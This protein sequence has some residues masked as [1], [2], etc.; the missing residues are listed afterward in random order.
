M[1][2]VRCRLSAAST[3]VQLQ[4]SVTEIGSGVQLIGNTVNFTDEGTPSGTGNTTAWGVAYL[5]VVTVPSNN[6]RT[7]TSPNGMGIN[8]GSSTSYDVTIGLYAARSAGAGVLYVND[9]IFVPIDE[10]AIRLISTG[11]AITAAAT[12]AG[13]IYDNTGYMTHGKP[14]EYATLA[15]QNVTNYSEY[16]R[17]EIRG[18]PIYLTP[19]V[20]NRLAF[21]A[22]T[23]S[24]LRSTIT[25]PSVMSLRLSIVP[26]WSGL[27]DV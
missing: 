20:D 14:D 4:L 19:G 12:Q 10:G 17:L 3:T 13:V 8:I 6:R 23:D 16:D 2:F 15:Q 27:R 24:S 5:G 26:R 25:S 11:Q 7:V 18:Q 9:I 22:Y 21:F 1:A